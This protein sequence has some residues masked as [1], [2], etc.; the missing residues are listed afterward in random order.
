MT[1]TGFF[2]Y[3]VVSIAA[4]QRLTPPPDAQ[5][6]VDRVF[7]QFKSEASPGCAAGVSLDGTPVL[8]AAYGMADLE[9]NVPITPESVFEPGSVTKQF[10]AAAVLL[11]AQQGK[12]SLDD[13]VRK[14]FPELPDYGAPLTIRHLLNHTS[15]L[16]DWGELEAI[17]GWP[18]T[19]RAYTHAHVLEIIARQKALNYTP[20]AEY[21]YT[22]SGYNLAAMLV[23]RVSGKSLPEFTREAIFQPLDMNSTQWR[24]DFRRIVKNRAIAYTRAGGA[25]RMDM[26]FEH[27]FGNGGLLTTVGDLL[28]WNQ[29]FTTHKVGGPEML[30]AQLQQGRLNDGRTIAYAGG[31]MVLHWHDI[32]EVSHSGSTAGYSAWLGRYPEQ[33]LSVAVLCNVTTNATQFGH[34]VADVYLAPVIHAA[35]PAAGATVDAS[36]LEGR[37]G[38]YRSV[39]DHHAITLTAT[40]GQL[41]VAGR[42]ALRP[43]SA[44]VFTAGANGRAEFVD[45][46]RLRLSNETDSN[47]VYEKV[48]RATPTRAELEAFAGV[49]TSDEIEIALTVKV[50]PDGL[51]IHRRPADVIPLSPTYRD[52]FSSSLGS[53]RFLR[54]GS[55]RVTG[56]SIGEGRV[57]DLRFVRQP[58]PTAA[59]K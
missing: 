55:G 57:W 44:T 39:R 8:S 15:G 3:A 19:T 40:N 48:E 50:D 20:G 23:E 46:N 26:P 22:N 9:H 5:A 32:P 38:L 10:T 49:Y 27:I 24:D 28:R 12:L 37:T 31:L 7:A 34:Q 13:P 29:N 59:P 43:V 45:G 16:R 35:P 53:V 6:R 47:D 17:A 21:S 1:R 56:M 11:L 2:L 42:G 51:A 30:A 33:G 58:S 18:R 54:D 36:A 25:F 41:A 4:A 14:Y 52:G